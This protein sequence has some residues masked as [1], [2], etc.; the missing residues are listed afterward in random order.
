VRRPGRRRASRRR[1]ASCCPCR[2]ET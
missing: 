1:P 2:E